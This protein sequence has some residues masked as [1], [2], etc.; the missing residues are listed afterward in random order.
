MAGCSAK[1][2]NPV[3]FEA[4]DVEFVA[5]N[6]VR[7]LCLNYMPA[8]QAVIL[9][10]EV[11]GCSDAAAIAKVLHDAGYS[12]LHTIEALKAAMGLHVSEARVV[13]TDVY[14]IVDPSNFVPLLLDA[15]YAISGVAQVADVDDPVAWKG[16]L[17]GRNV[18]VLQ[19]LAQ[20]FGPSGVINQPLAMAEKLSALGASGYEAIGI[21]KGY[22][23]SPAMTGLILWGNGYPL[24]TVYVGVGSA[25]TNVSGGH[26]MTET[27][28]VLKQMTD[29]SA[30][31]ELSV[32]AKGTNPFTDT[33][34]AKILA[35]YMFFITPT[36]CSEEHPGCALMFETLIAAG[37]TADQAAEIMF[38]NFGL[39]YGSLGT[40]LQEI[41]GYTPAAPVAAPLNQQPH[42][43]SLKQL[44]AALGGTN[45]TDSQAGVFGP[46]LHS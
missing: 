20:L 14:D 42:E 1:Q 33:Q 28:K 15:G 44:A 34:V 13:L 29:C 7:Q 5:E 12:A 17:S 31:G 16:Y 26:M 37:Y 39:D 24:E 9:L 18:G 30:F 11:F 45:L 32:C 4:G 3:L 27:A 2:V 21:L 36:A 25:M 22:G 40:Y 46:V 41:G 43:A 38:V 19:I 35:D 10:R 8:A 23:Y 6:A